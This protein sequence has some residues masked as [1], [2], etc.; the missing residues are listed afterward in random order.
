MDRV[1]VGREDLGVAER[2]HHVF[3]AGD[4]HA[5]RC[6][7][8]GASSWSRWYTGCG[9]ATFQSLNVGRNAGEVLRDQR[10]LVLDLPGPEQVRRSSWS[11]PITRA[12]AC[13]THIAGSPY[14]GLFPARDDGRMSTRWQRTD[15]PR[16]DDYDAR[17]KRLAAAGQRIHGEA[18][19]VEALLRESG[20]T[21]VLDGGCGTGRVAIELAARGYTSSGVDL[22]AGML[23]RG[24]QE[25]ARRSPGSRP[26]SRS[27]RTSPDS[28]RT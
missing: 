9:Q 22:D 2:E 10:R 25:G 23:D 28:G 12:H 18:D 26:T 4:H 8:H 11:P 3:V 13:L 15:A 17:W 14:P 16:G 19:L 1:H 27:F 21:R 6:L 7:E 5:D 20:G 24:A